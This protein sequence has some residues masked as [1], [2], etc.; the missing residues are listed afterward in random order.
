MGQAGPLGCKAEISVGSLFRMY[1]DRPSLLCFCSMPSIII[2]DLT[3]KWGKDNFI[4]ILFSA[5]SVGTIGTGCFWDREA[6]LS[7]Y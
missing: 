4:T 6:A 1:S 3:G 2:G 7:Y 5:N